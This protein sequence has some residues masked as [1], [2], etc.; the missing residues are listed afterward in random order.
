MFIVF[1]APPMVKSWIRPCTQPTQEYS[2]A[3]VFSVAGERAISSPNEH[4]YA[5]CNDLIKFTDMV[6]IGIW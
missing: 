4:G 2:T 1:L 5:L 3:H 6:W